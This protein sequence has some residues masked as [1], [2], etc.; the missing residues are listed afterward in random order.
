MKF[1]I[2]DKVVMNNLPNWYQGVQ[3]NDKCTVVSMGCS[4]ILDSY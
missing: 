2:G 1:K 3:L 4:P